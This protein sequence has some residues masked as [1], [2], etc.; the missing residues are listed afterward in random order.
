M[1]GKQSSLELQPGKHSPLPQINP[2]KQSLLEVHFW[3][4]VV[5]VV[6][7]VVEVIVVVF[8]GVGSCSQYLKR[9]LYTYVTVKHLHLLSAF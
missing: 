2:L 7:V 4:M 1:V 9:Q 8:D 5:V 6:V 3:T